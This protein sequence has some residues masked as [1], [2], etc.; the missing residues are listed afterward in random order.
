M[1]SIF[2]AL[3]DLLV[4]I[5]ALLTNL[6]VVRY[7]LQLADDNYLFGYG[8]AEFFAALAQSM[9]IFGLA[10]FLFLTGI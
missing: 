6:L 5:G 9:F 2:A 7:F 10:L 3:V 4:D 8:K 1:V